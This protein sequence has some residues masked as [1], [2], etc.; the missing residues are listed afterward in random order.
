MIL[1]LARL[2]AERNGPQTRKEILNLLRLEP[3]LTKTQVCRRL[4]LGWGTVSYHLRVLERDRQITQRRFLGF[5]RIY[6][7]A[8]R[9]P[10]AAL[11]PLLRESIVPHLLE[12]VHESPGIG[13]QALSRELSLGRKVVRR[14]LLALVQNGL[15]ERSS[16][17]RPKFYIREDGL[18]LVRQSIPWLHGSDPDDHYRMHQ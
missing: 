5:N 17:Y 7:P 1:L 18:D 4:D 3:G 8:A 12:R 6:T 13:I 14:H 11:M 16:H 15:V 2:G 9:S 10:E